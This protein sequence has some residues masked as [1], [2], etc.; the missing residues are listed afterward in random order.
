MQYS[1][2]IISGLCHGNLPARHAALLC[3][4]SILL[5]KPISKAL[6][7]LHVLV[8]ASHDA[9]FF[10]RGKRLALEAV[11]AGIETGLHKV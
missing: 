8:Y 6:G 5:L 7:A 11:D 9:A 2:L 4:G 10:A 3:H 1:S